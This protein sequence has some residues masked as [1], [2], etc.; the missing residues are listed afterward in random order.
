MTEP[1][2]LDRRSALT[3]LGGLLALFSDRAAFALEASRKK[4]VEQAFE[5]KRR[6]VQA[7]DQAYGAVVVRGDEI[8]GFGPSRVVL[9]SDWTAHAERE[10][11]RDAQSRLGG[12]LSGCVL[13]S[14]SQPCGNCEQ[15]AAE[16]RI[17]RMYYGAEATDAGP[18]RSRFDAVR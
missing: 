6:A 2:P 15:A 13:Y 11:I 4:F 9:R 12:D 8:V 16:A 5:M 7:G 18:P 10:A 14:T 17:A 3:W 1:L